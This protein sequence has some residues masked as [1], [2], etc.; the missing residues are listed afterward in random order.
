MLAISSVVVGT[1]TGSS[2]RVLV[3]IDR[4]IVIVGSTNACSDVSAVNLQF[5]NPTL[6]IVL[7]TSFEGLFGTQRANFRSGQVLHY[8][9]LPT[10]RGMSG[11]S[12]FK[13]L[14]MVTGL[15]TLLAAAAM[16][17]LVAYLWWD[18]KTATAD[19]PE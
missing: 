13:Q 18:S 7:D 10:G 12:R 2:N 5:L 19:I 14:P 8:D 3:N 6:L 9:G 16:A 17:G 4:D 11:T 15:L 1:V